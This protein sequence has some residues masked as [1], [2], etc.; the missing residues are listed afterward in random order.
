MSLHLS[1][2]LRSLQLLGGVE[3]IEGGQDAL[4][5]TILWLRANQTVAGLGVPVQ[6]ATG[7]FSLVCLPRLLTPAPVSCRRKEA[8]PGLSNKTSAAISSPSGAH[9]IMAVPPWMNGSLWHA[10]V[11]NSFL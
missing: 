9:S 5:R 1:L 2:R 3:G 7:A 10:A 6:N 8:R 11:L 4:L